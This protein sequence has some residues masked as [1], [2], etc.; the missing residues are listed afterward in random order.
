VRAEFTFGKM[1]YSL[2]VTDPTWE[3]QCFH[4]GVGTHQKV[5]PDSG[6]AAIVMLTVSLAAVPFHGFHYK[7]VAGVIQLPAL[8][9][10]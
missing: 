5:V 2:V 1:P 9:P 8:D 6:R 4:L 3:A 10:A 7:L